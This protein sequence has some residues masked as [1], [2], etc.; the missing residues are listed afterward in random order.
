MHELRV[1]PAPQPRLQA[2]HVRL[3]RGPELNVH[4][5][6]A[7]LEHDLLGLVRRGDQRPDEEAADQHG[8]DGDL[9]RE[10]Q[11]EPRVVDPQQR[12]LLLVSSRDRGR[13][14]VP[15]PQRVR[16]GV[17]RVPVPVL[18]L[19]K[20]RVIVPS[21]DF[22]VLE[23]VQRLELD[24][25]VP[26]VD[27]R[28][29][30]VHVVLVLPP[31]RAEP[32]RE[33]SEPAHHRAPLP[34]AVDVIVREP[35][36]LLHPEAQR[37]RR[38]DRVRPREEPPERVQTEHLA[39]DA[40]FL[41]RIPREP[42][43]VLELLP[44]RREV[45]VRVT[46][47]GLDR[48]VRIA[49]DRR[50]GNLASSLLLLLLFLLLLRAVAPRQHREPPRREVVAVRAVRVQRV[51]DV[52]RVAPVH[53]RD[54]ERSAGVRLRPARAVVP[55][56]VDPQ[57]QRALR[58]LLLRGRGVR[59]GRVRDRGLERAQER[60]MRR[61][62]RSA[63]ERDRSATHHDPVVAGRRRGSGDGGRDGGAARRGGRAGE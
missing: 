59:G 20:P 7:L 30:V 15:A 2:L 14:R 5:L 8:R 54:E 31:L 61:H 16:R 37:Q 24:V 32:V 17:Q 19:S 49:H 25:P 6:A 11:E 21:G 35:P 56:A 39:Q 23:I 26:P 55:L 27:V 38:E 3:A 46:R 52:R 29:R 40:R 4:E 22:R 50:R 9:P 57:S 58:L 51:E 12:Q 44:Q 10:T 13:H 28:E 42:P 41:E 53:E 60:G 33:G 45:C 63:T 43:L 1:H 36:G 18:P 34:A 62:R 47:L 48:V